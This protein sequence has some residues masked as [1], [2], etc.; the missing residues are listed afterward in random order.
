MGCNLMLPD[1]S[2]HPACACCLPV[3]QME[4][5]ITST[6][7]M[8]SDVGEISLSNSISDSTTHVAIQRRR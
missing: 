8:A 1:I 3:E 6:N 5:S 7:K 4:A 2:A